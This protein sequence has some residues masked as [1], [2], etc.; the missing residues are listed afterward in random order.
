METSAANCPTQ[1]KIHPYRGANGR[2]SVVGAA[3]GLL[4][5]NLA[6]Y[7]APAGTAFIQAI[8]VIVVPIVFTV[9]TLG[10]HQ[11]GRTAKQLGRVTTVSLVYFV[12]ATVISIVIGLVLNAIFRPGLGADLTGVGKLPANFSTAINWSK[13]FLDMIPSNIV[14]AMAGT[15]L[16]PVLVFAVALGLALSAIGERAT[17]MITGCRFFYGSHLQDDEVDHRDLSIRCLRHHCLAVRHAGHQDYL[18]AA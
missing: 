14:A 4:A 3:F 9:I 7:L 12:V 15:N 17:P 16:L 1:K 8:K 5:P 11:M 10:V 18:L 13:F 6:K 2:R